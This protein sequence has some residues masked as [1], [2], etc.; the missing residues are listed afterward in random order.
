MNGLFFFWANGRFEPQK[1]LRSRQARRH[2]LNIDIGK[3]FRQLPG[4]ALWVDDLTRV[5]IERMGVDIRRQNPIVAIQDIRS[6]GQNLCRC[7]AGLGL[8]RLRDR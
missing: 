2:F 8:N 7:G 3:Y 5:R 1:F 4:G 6:A